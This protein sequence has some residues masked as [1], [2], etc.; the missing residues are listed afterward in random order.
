MVPFLPLPIKDFIIARVRIPT[1]LRTIDVVMLLP[2]DPRGD[3]SARATFDADEFDCLIALSRSSM[4]NKKLIMQNAKGKIYICNV[5]N[6]LT[7]H[8]WILPPQA[9]RRVREDDGICGAGERGM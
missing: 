1:T 3:F 8:H 5:I 4:E 7:T 9:D 6:F 2:S